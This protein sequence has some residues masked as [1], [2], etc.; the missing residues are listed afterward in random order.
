M[1][2]IFSSALAIRP[3]A[4]FREY[5]ILSCASDTVLATQEQ[6]SLCLAALDAR[7]AVAFWFLVAFLWEDCMSLSTQRMLAMTVCTSCLPPSVEPL[8]SLPKID[9]AV[10][11]EPS[12]GPGASP[13]R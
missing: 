4:A 11:S 13:R 9:G 8:P 2:A 1:P 3:F 5:C 7:S 6:R 10:S 12:A